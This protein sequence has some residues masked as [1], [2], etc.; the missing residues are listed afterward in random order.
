MNSSWLRLGTLIFSAAIAGCAGPLGPDNSVTSTTSSR[1]S[2]EQTFRNLLRVMKDCYPDSMTIRSN[3]FPE[4]K[5]GE[6]ELFSG[7]DFGNIPFANWTV[8]PAPTG[9][10]VTQVRSTRTRGLDASL[11]EWVD[12]NSRQCPHGT[13]SDPRP[14]GSEL[15]P[16]TMP[17]R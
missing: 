5:E 9:S 13:R 6:I 17:V 4:A 2:S 14:S 1:H 12:G 8:K 10:T 16:N 7:N 3:F 11:S 15:S